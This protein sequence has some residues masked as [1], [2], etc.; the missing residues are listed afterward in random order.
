VRSITLAESREISKEAAGNSVRASPGPP[1]RDRSVRA[2]SNLS[3]K[4]LVVP[5]PMKRLTRPL[6]LALPWGVLALQAWLGYRFV[7]QHGRSLLEQDRLANRLDRLEWLVADLA[8]REIGSP[9]APCAAPA[10]GTAATQ[11]SP[12]AESSAES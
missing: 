10:T 8:S 9:I 7:M 4:A 6:A 3:F 5:R 11:F 12:S 1:Y 2:R